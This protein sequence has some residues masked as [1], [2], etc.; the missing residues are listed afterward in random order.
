MTPSIHILLADDDE[1]DVR[2]A[3]MVL[4]SLSPPVRVQVVTDGKETLD[5]L[6]RRGAFADRPPSQPSLVLLDLKMPRVDG[7]EVLERVKSDPAL[8]VIPIV[9]LTSSRQDRDLT[10]AYE[11]GANGYVVKAL[12]F[13]E[14]KAALGAVTRFWLDVNQAPPSCLGRSSG[15]THPPM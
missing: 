15:I 4:Q 11:L 2:L 1:G 10:R 14:Y 12:H 7:F 3:T 5:F 8:K 13:E 9:V 6:Q